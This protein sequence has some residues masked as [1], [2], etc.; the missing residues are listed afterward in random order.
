VTISRPR[1]AYDLL[2]VAVVA[3]ALRI[4]HAFFLRR[5]PFLE[6]PVIDAQVYRSFAEQLARTGDFGG[7]FYQ[8]P[9]YPA[10]LALLLRMGLGSPWSVCVVQ[11]LMGAA[12]AALMLL[13]GRRLAEHAD[14]A[15][16]AGLL[17][18]LLTAA[19]GPFVLFDLEL[20]PP[21]IVL[22]LLASA[23]VLALRSGGLGVRDAALGLLLGAAI[24][25]WPLIAVLV[26]GLCA[27]RARRVPSRRA[28]AAALLLVLA[29]TAPPIALTAR[30]N[31]AHDGEGILV[32]YNSGINLW[33]GNNPRWRDTWRARPGAAF[34]PELERPDREGV[35]RPAD[36]SRYFVEL[37][38]ADVAAHPFAAAAR[39]AEKFYYVWH[40]REI[41]RNQDIALLREASPVLALLLWEAGVAFPFGILA[42]LAL[43]GIWRRRR[44]TDVRILAASALLYALVLAAFFAAARYRLPLVLFLLPLGAV[45]ILRLSA[46]GRT[47]ARSLAALLACVALLNAPNAFTQSFAAGEA[48]RGILRAHAFRNQGKREQAAQISEQ[49]AGRFPTDA[50]VQMLR[51]EALLD[52]GRCELALPHLQRVTE[53]APRAATPWVMLG[54]CLGERGDA[55]GAERAFATALSLHPYHAIALKRAA[56]LYAQ[57]GRVIEARSLLTR[58]VRSGYHDREVAEWL[59]EH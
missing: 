11:S 20:L 58:F 42:P 28:A 25:G 6:G 43:L 17:T 3:F 15:R 52:A 49:L 36:R 57:H 41:R 24:T 9:L 48:E 7:A 14:G 10:L 1:P 38:R 44:E 47:A 46:A 35:T 54:S 16:R 32:S 4:V 45:E 23:L 34:E 50:N 12:T 21:C 55:A 39:T 5:T 2:L 33:L 30:H 19:Y 51:A 29:F 13:V 53:L 27:L 59:S 40:G 8:P 31:A 56:A 26:P 37:V 18:G 22:L